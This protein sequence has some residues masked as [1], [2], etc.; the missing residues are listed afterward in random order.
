MHVNSIFVNILVEGENNL[1]IIKVII[2]IPRDV[3]M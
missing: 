1:F 2:K 3:N